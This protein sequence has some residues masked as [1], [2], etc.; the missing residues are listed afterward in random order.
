MPDPADR[1]AA[2]A[3]VRQIGHV[4]QERIGHGH[5][6]VVGVGALGSAIAH[7]LVR[8]GVGTVTLIDG[9]RVEL[10]NLHR[11][12][13]YTENDARDQKLKAEVAAE[14]LRGAN[15]QVRVESVVGHLDAENAAD[16]IRGAH[17]VVD[18]TD[19]LASRYVINDVCLGSGVPWVYG[20]VAGTHG[21]V[22]PVIPGRGPCLRCLFEDPPEH[23]QP[24]STTVGVF[25]PAPA[26]VGALEAA[27]AMRILV[28]DLPLPV[29]LL[30][31][32]VWSGAVESVPV[33]PSPDC[34]TCGHLH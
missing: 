9:D 1:Y 18:G 32:D 25:G 34:A 13:M 22:M 10:G 24:T 27:L 33:N 21:L 11:Q 30:S 29:H 28:G 2:Q 4:G 7:Q 31:I 3:R 6:V 19:N 5:V 20:G 8:G 14:R 15:S 23:E 12:I 17:V 16:L 26:V